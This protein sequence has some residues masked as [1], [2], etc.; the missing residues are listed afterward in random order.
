MNDPSIFG[1]F[2]AM[3]KGAAPDVLPKEEVNGLKVST[4]NTHDMGFETAILD[5][6]GAYCVQRYETKDQAEKGHQKWINMCKDGL[7][8]IVEI[9]YGDIVEPEEIRLE[10][11]A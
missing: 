11:N 4:V 8:E 5:K 2:G 9:G 6:N 3:T 1:M 7:T 10:A